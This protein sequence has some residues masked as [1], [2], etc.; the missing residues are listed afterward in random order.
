M[1]YCLLMVHAFAGEPVPSGPTPLAEPSPV[2][3]S[4]PAAI[5]VA[6]SAA[7]DDATAIRTATSAELVNRGSSYSTGLMARRV[8]EQGSDW[9]GNGALT[10]ADLDPEATVAIPFTLVEDNNVHILAT[11]LVEALTVSNSVGQPMAMAGRVMEVDGVRYVV[12][13]SYRV[14]QSARPR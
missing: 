12:L 8:M 2:T 14:L 3:P 11:E 9:V 5:T 4:D 1:V 13:T 10:A 6:P 7:V